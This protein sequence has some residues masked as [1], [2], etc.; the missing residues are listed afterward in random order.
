MSGPREEVEAARACSGLLA[1]GWMVSGKVNQTL[2]PSLEGMS[3]RP[4]GK[5]IEGE[6]CVSQRAK[7]DWIVTTMTSA[8]EV[9]HRRRRKRRDAKTRRSGTEVLSRVGWVAWGGRSFRGCYRMTRSRIRITTRDNQAQ[10]ESRDV[11]EMMV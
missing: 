4:R 11:A 7:Q 6:E 2:E 3:W 8:R 10:Q 9:E 1:R 5:R